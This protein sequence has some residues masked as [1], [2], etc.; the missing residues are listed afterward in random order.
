MASAAG[1]ESP[2]PADT[3]PARP[4]V[5]VSYSRGDKRFVDETLL[6]ALVAHGTEVW[7]DLEDMPPAADWRAQVLAGVAAANAVVFVIS[8]DSLASAVCGEELA[9]AVELNKRLIPVVR[10]DP[11]DAAVPPDLARPNWIWLREQ[12]DA[13]RALAG[14]RVQPDGARAALTSVEGPV[15]VWD[16]ESEK[17]RR[18]LLSHAQFPS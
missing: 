14:G 13:E 12:D 10:R 2:R 7:I 8:P 18:E 5:F 15:P 17:P 9:R 3:A 11:G 16:M 4:D 6:P 1:T